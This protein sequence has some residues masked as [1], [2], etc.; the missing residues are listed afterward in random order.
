[1]TESMI[2]MIPFDKI[3]DKSY[4]MRFMKKRIKNWV[5]ILWNKGFFFP[6][7]LFEFKFLS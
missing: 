1:M 7:R 5:I 6:V 2:T 4:V 3:E